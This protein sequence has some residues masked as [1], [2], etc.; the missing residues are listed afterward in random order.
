MSRPTR[1]PLRILVGCRIAQLREARGLSLHG[2][3]KATGLSDDYM[4]KLEKG[5]RSASLETISAVAEALSCE[6]PELLGGAEPGKSPSREQSQLLGL[7][8]D[9]GDDDVRLVLAL[10]RRLRSRR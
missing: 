5:Q 1:E 3:A 8:A 2:L 9:L 7:A 10:I 6:P 4:L